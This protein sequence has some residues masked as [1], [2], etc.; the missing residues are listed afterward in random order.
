MIPTTNAMPNTI[1]P[2]APGFRDIF[3][4][5]A[6]DAA[7]AMN[8]PSASQCRGKS[9]SAYLTLRYGFVTDLNVLGPEADTDHA[10]RNPAQHRESP[11]QPEGE[12]QPADFSLPVQCRAQYALVRNNL[13]SLC[14]ARRKLASPLHCHQ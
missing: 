7:V 11:Q 6:G 13:K 5:S 10:C 1:M 4:S 12:R 9:V 14:D 2:I 3:F 8:F